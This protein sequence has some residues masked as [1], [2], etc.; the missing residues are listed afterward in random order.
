M[1]VHRLLFRG[2]HEMIHFMTSRRRVLVWLA[3]VSLVL[4]WP[5]GTALAAPTPSPSTQPSP[6][7]TSAPSPTARPI[8]GPKATLVAFSNQEPWIAQLSGFDLENVE[9][10]TYFVR[11][12]AQH[13]HSVGPITDAPFAAELEWWTWN[14]AG[15][16]VV[17]SHVQMQV[18][19]NAVKDPGGWTTV[20]GQSVNPG[21]SFE[22]MA[23]SDGSLG[24][25][26]TPARGATRIAAVQFW[27]RTGGQWNQVAQ[28]SQPGATGSFEAVSIP[29]TNSD[30]WKSN[31]TAMSVHVVW[32]G[33]RQWVDP[34]P[35]AW[36]D[37]FVA[38]A[39]PN[40]AQATVPTAAPAAPPPATAAPIAAATP[41]PAAPTQPPAPPAGCYPLTNSG[42]CY[43]P[44]EFC[45]TSDHGRTGLAGD[46]RA[47]ICENNDGWRW[48]PV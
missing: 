14:D 9:S 8:L 5:V 11:D 24:A 45:R 43:E 44:G 16:M 35:W 26:Y 22:A 31:D 48:E 15:Q 46:G 40:S 37:H 34:V 27:L 17:T 10:A 20:D 38:A 13:W 39:A 2:V 25:R 28:V 19:A 21:G 32:P 42:G 41:L 30:G 47:I 18:G 1:I 29:G 12:A 33:G 3:V 36:R 6:T 4:F 23:N 7:P